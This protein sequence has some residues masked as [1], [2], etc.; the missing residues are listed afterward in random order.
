MRRCG[1]RLRTGRHRPFSGRRQ[2]YEDIL[3]RRTGG[4]DLGLGRRHT[5]CRAELLRTNCRAGQHVDGLPNEGCVQYPVD[6]PQ[7]RQ[8]IERGGQLQLQALRA[9]WCDGRQRLD[10]IR[11]ARDQEPR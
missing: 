6:G 9:R 5:D 11:F 3:Q 10:G 7:P 8:M 4:P 1:S 2:G